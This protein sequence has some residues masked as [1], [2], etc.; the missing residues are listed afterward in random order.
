SD[1]STVS[2]SVTLSL[3]IDASSMIGSYTERFTVPELALAYAWAFNTRP[4][5]RFSKQ[6]LR[7]RNVIRRVD[8]RWDELAD[9]H[10]DF[11]VRIDDHVVRIAGTLAAS[12]RTTVASA[13]VEAAWNLARRAVRDTSHLI[14]MDT[15]MW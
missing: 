5:L 3:V 13:H 1:G 7:L 12:E 11:F 9:P 8:G 15:D 2:T 10:A 14:G 4:F 6:A